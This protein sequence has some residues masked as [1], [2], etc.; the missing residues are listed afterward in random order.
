LAPTDDLAGGGLGH[1]STTTA[2]GLIVVVVVVLPQWHDAFSFEKAARDLPT[3]LSPVSE[4]C[5]SK[6]QG[7]TKSTNLPAF[8]SWN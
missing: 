1:L 3:E 2:A 8:A 5:C 7:G 4:G 6:L